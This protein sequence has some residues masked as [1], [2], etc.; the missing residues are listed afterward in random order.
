MNPVTTE[1]EG[2]LF[3][4]LVLDP[5]VILPP[6]HPHGRRTVSHK[7][8]T[9]VDGAERRRV[10]RTPRTHLWVTVCHWAMV[11]LLAINLLSGMRIG[12]GFQESALG[13]Q[14][15]MWAALLACVSRRVPY[16]ASIYSRYT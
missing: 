2:T 7:P 4:G 14:V 6:A 9:N 11:S 16:S 8:T 1:P 15:G 12:W 10:A 5:G 3:K 13:G